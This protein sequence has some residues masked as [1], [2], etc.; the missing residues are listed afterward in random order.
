MKLR[1]GPHVRIWNACAVAL[2]IRL[3]VYI[4]HDIVVGS[5]MQL[6]NGAGHNVEHGLRPPVQDELYQLAEASP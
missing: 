4:Q 5:W 3:R 6:R 2:G 1:V